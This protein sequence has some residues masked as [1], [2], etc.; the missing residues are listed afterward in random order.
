MRIE[1]GSG[2]CTAFISPFG[3]F[4]YKQMPFGLAN[5]NQDTTLQNKAVSVQVGVPGAQDQQRRHVYDPE[6]RTED[7]GLAHAKDRERSSYILGIHQVL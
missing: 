2:A 5:W 7:Q 3:T 6:I 4:L 1:P